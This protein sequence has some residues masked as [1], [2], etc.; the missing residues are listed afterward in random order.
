[1]TDK[2]DLPEAERT[3][4]VGSPSQWLNLWPFLAGA[5][6]FWLVLPALWAFWRYMEVRC[7]KYQLSTQRLSIRTGVFNVQSVDVE[8]YRIKDH[9]LD[10]PFLLRLVGLGNVVLITSDSTY[11]HISLRAIGNADAFRELLRNSVEHVRDVKGVR[12]IDLNR[13]LTS[14]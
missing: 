14:L 3:L 1:M 4:W 8:H 13:E 9:S 6:F 12:E 10:Q 7:T 5:C 11:H 2:L